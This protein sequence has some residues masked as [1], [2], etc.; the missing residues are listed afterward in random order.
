LRHARLRRMRWPAG[1]HIRR[2]HRTPEAV[3]PA[4]GRAS[5]GTPPPTAG[6]AAALP[7]RPPQAAP[8]RPRR[9]APARR[10]TVPGA[11][12]SLPRRAR[13]G[14]RRQARRRQSRRFRF[15]AMRMK[16]SR[17]SSQ[18]PSHTARVASA[19]NCGPG[20]PSSRS[21]AS[22][23]AP[24]VPASSLRAGRTRHPADSGRPR[25]RIPAF[26]TGGAPSPTAPAAS[27]TAAIGARAFSRISSNSASGSER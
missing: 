13:P 15:P 25:V 18:K 23:A 9:R 24:T 3:R 10:P 16:P 21:S 19:R 22:T 8:S 7:R 5:A 20:P 11:P 26:A 1:V 4:D 17:S 6:P 27:A 2:G 14:P 12:R